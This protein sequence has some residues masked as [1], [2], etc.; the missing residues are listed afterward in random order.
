M[1]SAGALWPYLV[2]ILAGFIPNEAFR[3]AAV[4]L[5]RRV[6]EASELFAWIRIVATTLLAA[7][8]S[9]LIYS[10]A[11]SLAVVPLSVRAGSIAVGVAAFFVLKRSIVAAILTG[12]A[13]FVL[14]AW[15]LTLG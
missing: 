13:A 10:P 11:A 12:E 3:I 4:L 2:V 15:W 5:S 9:R 14:A 1:T 7:V 6:D 8:V